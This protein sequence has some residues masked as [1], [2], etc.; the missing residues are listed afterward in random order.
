MS[1]LKGRRPSSVD[2][3]HLEALEKTPL[4]GEIALTSGAPVCQS[5]LTS[6]LSALLPGPALNSYPF[7]AGNYS[8]E[9]PRPVKARPA[10]PG[11]GA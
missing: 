5:L 8:A 3:G 2:T 4:A 9:A 6:S 10:T 11:E 7:T 1:G